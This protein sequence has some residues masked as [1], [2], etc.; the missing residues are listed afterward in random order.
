MLSELERDDENLLFTQF[1][2]EVNVMFVLD[3]HLYG[4][5]DRKICKRLLDVN[6]RASACVLS[7]NILWYPEK[8]LL[9]HIPSLTKQID[10]KNL[11]N[12]RL[13][14]IA[15]RSQNLPKETHSL[16]FQVSKSTILL[17][18]LKY[19]SI[20]YKTPKTSNY[21]HLLNYNFRHACGCWKLKNSINKI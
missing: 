9:K 5:L 1:W 16:C 19:T 11:S 2:L 4:T 8:F 12:T 14:Q 18:E 15:I 10:L 21:N 6:K 7:G 17:I 13:T 20:Y 3:Y